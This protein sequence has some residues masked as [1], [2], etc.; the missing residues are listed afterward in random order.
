[1]DNKSDKKKLG[2]QNRTR[3][4]SG[5][6][7][8]RASCCCCCCCCRWPVMDR[9]VSMRRRKSNSFISNDISSSSSS[10]SSTWSGIHSGLPGLSILFLSI[11]T[12][13]IT[14][15]S[16]PKT[17]QKKQTKKQQQPKP[18]KPTA[19]TTTTTTRWNL[20]RSTRKT[21]ATLGSPKQDEP[22]HARAIKKGKHQR[23]KKEK[24]REKYG[25]RPNKKVS[26][27]KHTHTNFLLTLLKPSKKKPSTN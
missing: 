10:S 1:M 22:K 6:A 13:A 7:A 23:K 8:I 17:S 11:G 2:K 12:T 3:R 15:A 16:A 26:T 9:A 24:G 19:T 5:L 27:L 14:T 20:K 18:Q 4:E 25:D 21:R